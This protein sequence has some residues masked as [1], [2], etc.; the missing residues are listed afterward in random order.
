MDNFILYFNLGWKHIISV[1]AFDHQLFLLALTASFTLRDFRKIVLLVTAFTVG[2]CMTLALSATGTV[3][4]SAY[5][6]EILIPATIGMMAITNFGFISANTRRQNVSYL[7]AILF[8]LVHGLGFANVLK[9]LLGREQSLFLP[10]FGFNIGIELGQIA[11]I[12]F[13]LALQTLLIRILKITSGHWAAFASGL[14]LAGS[15]WMVWARI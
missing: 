15:V 1:D 4:M 7:L 6:I 3:Q 12:F 13:L 10:L 11:V 14:A 5:W 8:G 2:H 9:S